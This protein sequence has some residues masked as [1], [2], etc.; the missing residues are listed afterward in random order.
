MAMSRNFVRYIICMFY[1]LC[2]INVTIKTDTYINFS[3]VCITFSVYGIM[4]IPTKNINKNIM[5]CLGLK[6]LILQLL[7]TSVVYWF[8]VLDMLL[9]ILNVLLSGLL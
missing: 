9:V 5:C 8:I 4:F 6:L 7:T 3:Y 1:F 2:K